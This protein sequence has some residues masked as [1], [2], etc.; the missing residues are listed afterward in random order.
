MN[1]VKQERLL[2]VIMGP[3]VTE[4]SQINA[5]KHRQ[6]TFQ[7]TRDANKQEIKEAVEMLFKVKVEGV[8]VAN[9]KGKVKRFSNTLGR[10]NHWKKAYVSLAEGHDINF[11]AAEA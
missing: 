5:D 6:I 7:V 8:R 1:T 9:M 10:R 2:K 3:L 11:G 4:K